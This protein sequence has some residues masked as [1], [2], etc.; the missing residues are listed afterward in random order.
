[1]IVR[2][3]K[4]LFGGLDGVAGVA[5]VFKVNSDKADERMADYSKATLDQFAKE[6]G[7]KNNVFD[8]FVDGLNRLPRPTLAL[9]V[10][11]LFGSAMSSPEWF[12]ERMVGIALVPDQL[13]L[14][15]A[16]IVAFY[17]GGRHQAKAQSFELTKHVAAA[18]AVVDARSALQEQY[19]RDEEGPVE[20]VNPIKSTVD[21][22]K[23]GPV[24]EPPEYKAA[25]EYVTTPTYKTKP[26]H[27][28]E[29]VNDWL[30]TNPK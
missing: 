9:S 1:M 7:K 8:S 18:K 15:L 28:N 10:I 12:S 11:A 30:M 29:A 21:L 27:P 14:L 22:K 3:L 5:E 16:T 19:G 25:A 4:A 13:W 23:E 20:Q 26:Q 17:F 24:Y 6:F 2:T